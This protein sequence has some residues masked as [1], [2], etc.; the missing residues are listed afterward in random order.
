MMRAPPVK[1]VTPGTNKTCKS[2]TPMIVIW[3]NR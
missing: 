2:T 1:N 3:S